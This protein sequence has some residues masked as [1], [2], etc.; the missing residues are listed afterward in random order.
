MSTLINFGV[1]QRGRFFVSGPRP[2][3]L[4]VGRRVASF[5]CLTSVIRAACRTVS[6]GARSVGLLASGS[7]AKKSGKSV[8]S[9]GTI[10]VWI[11]S[12]TGFRQDWHRVT[13]LELLWRKL[14][15]LASPDVCV[16]T[17]QR[18][19]D[20]AVALADYIARNSMR[21][22]VVFF[23]G[24]SYG[25]GH[26]FVRLAEAL[27]AHGIAVETAVLCDGI[28][29]FRWLKWLSAKW[30]R[31]LFAIRVPSNVSTVYAFFQREDGLLHGHLVCA[32]DW[33][34]T[35]VDMIEQHGYD[36]CSIDESGSYHRVAIKEAEDVIHA[37]LGI[38]ALDPDRR[39]G[40]VNLNG[41]AL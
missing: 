13:G 38:R 10:A 36:H 33:D 6:R 29:R 27:Q 11:V 18:W 39:R 12:A 15:S 19:D 30:F 28:K 26:Y 24:Y 25:A 9:T 3:G 14:R 2:G 8:A 1:N 22:P 5:F 23:T 41:G 35:A 34:A 4:G 31:G 17:P 37:R 16:L 7:S 21:K 40:P 20:D 32:E